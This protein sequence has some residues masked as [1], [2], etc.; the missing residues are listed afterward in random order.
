MKISITEPGGRVVRDDLQAPKE[1]GINRVYWNLA[2]NQPPAQGRGADPQ[3]AA[4]GRGRG[5]GARGPQFIAQN[6][7]DPGTYV[8]K[9]TV[10]GKAFVTT[11][12]V[13]ADDIR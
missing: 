4:A 12:Q 9:L 2:P 11:V 1:A 3:A 8:V 13:E 7:V 10:G 5:R 6:A